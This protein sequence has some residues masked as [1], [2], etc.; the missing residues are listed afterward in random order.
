MFHK[1][2]GLQ[3]LLLSIKTQNMYKAQSLAHWISEGF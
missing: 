3:T 2:I 1:V